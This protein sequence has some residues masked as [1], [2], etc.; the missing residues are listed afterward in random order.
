MVSLLK[1]QYKVIGYCLS[2]V[3]MVEL[4]FNW[5]PIQ[6]YVNTRENAYC[7]LNIFFQKY[8]PGSIGRMRGKTTTTADRTVVTYGNRGEFQ[9]TLPITKETANVP[10]LKSK[11][12][13]DSL[14]SY[15]AEHQPLI[16]NI[17]CH[18][19]TSYPNQ[20][21][22]PIVS[23]DEESINQADTSDDKQMSLSPNVLDPEADHQ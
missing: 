7:L 20:H 10:I 2:Q 11:P 1:P 21:K 3:T 16:E 9:C 14:H 12:S 8:I 17:V 22:L 18:E 5:S 15:M 13:L 23:D 4:R 19:C 6:F